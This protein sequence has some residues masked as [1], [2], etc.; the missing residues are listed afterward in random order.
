MVIFLIGT[1]CATYGEIDDNFGKSYAT[2]KSGQILNPAASK[3]LKPVT[4][5]S[6]KAGEASMRQYTESFGKACSQQEAAPNFMV[7]VMS[8]DSEGTGQDGREK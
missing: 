4:G 1:G 6:G 8:K 7:P 2:A 5:L 3:N